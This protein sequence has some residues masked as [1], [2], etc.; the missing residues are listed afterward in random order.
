MLQTL[1]RT[2]QPGVLTAALL[3][4]PPPL[5]KRMLRCLGPRKAKKLQARLVHPD[6]IRL[7]DVEEARRRMAALAQE[8]AGGEE[9]RSAAA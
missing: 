2:A 7:S 4:A 5:L 9:G 1:L 6:P 3:G 8:L